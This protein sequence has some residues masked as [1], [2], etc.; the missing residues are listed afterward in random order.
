MYFATEKW[1]LLPFGDVYPYCFCGISLCKKGE[2]AMLEKFLNLDDNVEV[3]NFYKQ[4]NQWNIVLQLLTDS[5]FCP[6]CNLPSTRPHSRYTRKIQDLPINKQKV[7]FTLVTRK[8]FCDH[9]NCHVKIFTQRVPWLSSYGRR[10]KR[11]E[12]ILRTLAFSTSCLQA[13]K[14]SHKL[15]I[16]V[17]NDTLL[18]I[19]KNTNIE[20]E[21]SPFLSCG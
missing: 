5:A 17:S 3:M 13:E 11:C 2:E 14:I 8:W 18:R 7:I 21:G 1:L 20:Q 10:T 19:I 6:N 4:D 15:N 9:S 12:D 16:P